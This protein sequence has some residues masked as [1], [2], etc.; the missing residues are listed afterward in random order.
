M[1]QL[2]SAQSDDFS[3][4]VAEV[5]LGP[6]TAAGKLTQAHSIGLVD[7][8]T[9]SVAQESAE[10]EGGFPRKLVASAVIRQS[11]TVSATF[12]EMSRR[13]LDII[14]GNGIPAAVTEVSTTITADVLIGATDVVVADSAGFTVGDVAVIYQEG[15]P[16]S[17]SVV[18]LTAVDTSAP[19][20]LSFAANSLAQAYTVASG[21]VH[22]YK[23][24]PIK[25][26]AVTRVNYFAA[27][28]IQQGASGRPIVWN[29]WK[30]SIGGNMEYATNAEDYASSTM[31]LKILE[32][33]AVDYGVGGDLYHVAD[34]IADHPS[35]MAILS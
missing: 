35:G 5:R 29:L 11:G 31:E 34:Q 10:L 4:G 16:E 15:K 12:R 32:P 28:L 2:G 9:V 25:I 1:A 33:A 19:D 7:E 22:V 17:V 13:N 24:N 21:T 27:T 20:G 14:L 3:I 23:A 26:G 8:A 18:K 30:C 6:L